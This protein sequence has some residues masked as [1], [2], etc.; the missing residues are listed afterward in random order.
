MM[1]I[2]FLKNKN[3]TPSK[4]KK[5]VHQNTYEDFDRNVHV[6]ITE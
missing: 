3:I 6:L 1:A 4:K 2:F 5:S